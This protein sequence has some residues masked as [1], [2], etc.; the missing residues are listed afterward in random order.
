[1]I[2]RPRTS[3]LNRA[4]AL[5]FSSWIG[6]ALPAMLWADDGAT[7]LPD[8]GKVLP[9]LPAEQPTPPKVKFKARTPIDRFIARKWQDHKIRPAPLCSDEDFLRRVSLDITGVIPSLPQSQRFLKPRTPN[10]PELIDELLSSH[11]YADHWTIFWGDLLREKSRVRGM[12]NFAFRDYLRDS[13]R[14]NKPYDQWVTE[15]ITAEGTA[16]DSTAIGLIMGHKADANELTITTSHVFLGTQLMCAQC[17]DHKFEPW[18]QEDFKGM[19]AYWRGTRTRRSGT[20]TVSSANGDVREVPVREVHDNGEGCGSFLT[21][22]ESALG[23]GRAGLADLIVSRENPYFARVAVNRIW[24][25]LMGTGI[26]DPPDSFS[27]S[28]P[29][30]HPELLDWLALEFIEHDYDLKH[31]IRLICN[32]RSYQLAST[33]GVL[34]REL[35]GARLFQRMPLRRMTAEQLHDSIVQA[36]RVKGTD[37]RRFRPAIE[38]FYPA[39]GRSFRA[40]FGSHDRQ[41]V[42]ERDTEATIPQALELMNGRFIND[43]VRLSDR[44]PIHLWAEG[45]LDESSAI[46]KLFMLT[47]TRKPTKREMRLVKNHFKKGGGTKAAWSDLQWALI[48]TREF[49]FLH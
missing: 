24:A 42:H 26:V 1:M 12:P 23:R 15:M 18:L 48:N 8:T 44:H 37:Q 47:L 7:P 29:P 45:G 2:M 13:L 22:D 46:R 33:G 35:A 39:P 11:R 10:R 6:A 14:E 28:N 38:K 17:H 36:C 43:A 5:A 41:S 27:L 31:I 40:K 19:A 3:R 32:T 25:Q 20:R 34:R 9:P 21:G 30:S 49:M 4:V 16:E